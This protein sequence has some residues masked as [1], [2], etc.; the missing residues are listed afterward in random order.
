MK[1]EDDTSS[2]DTAAP[3][4]DNDVLG[5]ISSML[6]RLYQIMCTFKRNGEDETDT[7]CHTE[8]SLMLK[9]R[10]GTRKERCRLK[11]NLEII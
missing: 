10:T 9:N 6:P 4:N 1:M 3:L 2:A 11:S 8:R 7:A 5:Q